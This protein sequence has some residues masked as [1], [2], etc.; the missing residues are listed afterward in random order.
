VEEERKGEFAIANC[1]EMESM[2]T[3]V[4]RLSRRFVNVTKRPVQYGLIGRTGPNAACLVEEGPERRFE[5]V[6]RK[7]GVSHSMHRRAK[8]ATEMKLKIVT[9]IL[10]LLL[11]RGQNGQVLISTINTTVEAA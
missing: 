7:L 5:N 11:H 10:V 8:M 3:P 4:S 9:Q 6:W 2:G 1:R